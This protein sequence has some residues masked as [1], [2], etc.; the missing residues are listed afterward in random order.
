MDLSVD[1]DGVLDFNLL[2]S[3]VESVLTA[4]D[5]VGTHFSDFSGFFIKV[6]RRK[7]IEP[8]LIAYRHGEPII[9]TALNMCLLGNTDV[10]FD[11]V[12]FKDGQDTHLI[13]R[14]GDNAVGLT[15]AKM[16]RE[17]MNDICVNELG[18]SEYQAGKAVD[19]AAPC[20][21]CSERSRGE[22]R[23]CPLFFHQG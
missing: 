5:V 15:P 4:P 16:T 6:N 11:A 9:R 3:N 21:R 23:S 22:Y 19:K 7:V 1:E 2:M 13:L 8:C 20:L 14:N 12:N 18:L 17:E 10:R